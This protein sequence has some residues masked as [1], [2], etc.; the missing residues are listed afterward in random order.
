MKKVLFFLAISCLS[1]QSNN[2]SWASNYTITPTQL[3]KMIHYA[4][5]P[6]ILNMGEGGNKIKGSIPI[7][8]FYDTLSLSKLKEVLSSTPKSK[9][10]VLYCGCC[11]FATCPNIKPAYDRVRS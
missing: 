3:L 1:L 11:K 2:L 10:I 8:A 6:I 7:G 4:Q 5:K 9:Q